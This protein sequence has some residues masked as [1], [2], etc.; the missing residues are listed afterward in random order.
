MKICFLNH[1][2]KETTGAGRFGLN[3]IGRLRDSNP[4]MDA[5]VLTTLG[6][7]HPLEAPLLFR[8]RFQLLRALPKIRRIMRECDIVHALDG[9]PYGVIASLALVGLKK[10]FV[11]TAIGTGAI[12]P[13][14]RWYGWMLRWAYRRADAVIVIS[15]YTRREILKKLPDLTI[16]VINHAVDADEFKTATDAELTNEERSQIAAMK[17][18]IMSVGGWKRRKGF[19]Y[20]FTAFA[21]L[22]KRFPDMRSVVCGIGPKPHLTEPLGITGSVFYFKGIRWPF[23]KA[24]YRDA[25]LFMLLPCDDEKDVEGFGFAFLEAAASGIP[26]IGTRESG[27]EDAVADGMNGFLVPPEDVPAAVDAAI[28]ILSSSEL[29]ER[30]R[31]G[32]IEFARR[33]NWR[34]VIERYTEIYRALMIERDHRSR[35]R[36]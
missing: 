34:R 23:L 18:Y 11:I 3:L 1:D 30:F 13:L 29:R 5:V 28:R 20:S 25:E 9:Y 12:Q 16:E 6:C 4:G 10:K 24:L 8:N 14:W 36:P 19:E 27:A 2:L 22:R 32:S 26:V 33:M 31:R 15:N 21:E 17:P 35:R 7:G